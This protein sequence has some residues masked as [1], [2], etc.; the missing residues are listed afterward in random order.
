MKLLVYGT[1]QCPDCVQAQ[2]MLQ[3]AGIEFEYRNFAADLKALM[4]FLIIRDDPEHDTLFGPVRERGGIGIPCF[5][6]PD[7]EVTLDV[8]RVLELAKL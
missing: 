2:Q 3:Q 6:I 5:L 7:V 1:D 4:E 8:Q